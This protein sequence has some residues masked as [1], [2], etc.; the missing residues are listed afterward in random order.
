[1]IVLKRQALD[2]NGTTTVDV[3]E[4]LG[5]LSYASRKRKR[6][7]G[8]PR[9]ELGASA[10]APG[11]RDDVNV[12]ADGVEDASAVPADANDESAELLLSEDESEEELS[13]GD[14][15][16]SE[17]TD[18]ER[19]TLRRERAREYN[20]EDTFIDDSELADVVGFGGAAK[21]QST[22]RSGFFVNQ[23]VIAMA[24]PPRGGFIG[25][26]FDRDA[27]ESAGGAKSDRARTAEK[28]R[29][30]Y[31]KKHASNGKWLREQSRELKLKLKELQVC[32]KAIGSS[33]KGT[34]KDVL[35]DSNLCVLRELCRVAPSLGGAPRSPPSPFFF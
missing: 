28:K 10:V 14:E 12:T 20:L 16:F 4:L 17:D 2:P 24:S 19:S 15:M 25:L 31:L 26:T 8:A 23:G 5:K 34:D 33:T 9:A 13:S 11:L 35:G 1:M 27:P 30:E 6:P 22:A 32:A 29:E 21:Q 3:R 7:A 18:P